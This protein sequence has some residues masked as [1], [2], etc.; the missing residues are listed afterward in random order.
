MFQSSDIL[1]IEDED[2]DIISI[3]STIELEEAFR[4]V[5][6][7]TLKLFI[8]DED[9]VVVD[10][11]SDEEEEFVSVNKIDSEPRA[12]TVEAA[13]EAAPAPQ[14]QVPEEKK[15]QPA[16]TDASKV[17]EPELHAVL[18]A[19][20]TDPA[21]V[22]AFPVIL[23]TTLAMLCDESALKA[24]HESEEKAKAHASKV[25]S[26]LLDHPAVVAHPDRAVL[27]S[28]VTKAMPHLA[29]FV[30]TLDPMFASLMKNI[31]I[32]P[33]KI[34][35]LLPFLFRQPEHGMNLDIGEVD[36][37]SAGMGMGD[38]S[39]LLNSV[40][41]GFGNHADLMFQCRS[42][43]GMGRPACCKPATAGAPSASSTSSGTAPVHAHVQC[44]QCGVHPIVG[45]RYK[46]LHTIIS[47]T[48]I[49]TYTH[50]HIHTHFHTRT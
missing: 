25:L 5:G 9:G 47:N 48:H 20:L 49:D 37:A 17:E 2:K 26:T 39:S 45:G 46:V 4:V 10:D 38:M 12:V 50:T 31:R 41:G 40:L 27:L 23:E 43:M 42:P 22:A 16:A 21:V 3:S 36:L 7:Q 35:S 1:I 11:R 28:H 19:M 14:V 18:V 34:L 30:H 15:E 33:S 6:K 29:R 32:D 13:P 24:A 44:D 8:T